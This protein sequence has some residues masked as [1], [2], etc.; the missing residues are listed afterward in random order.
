ML[1]KL[2]VFR[3][4]WNGAAVF[5]KEEGFFQ[6]QRVA[7]P[8][9]G[10]GPALTAWHPVLAENL[11]DARYRAQKSRQEGIWPPLPPENL[12]VDA[13]VPDV[14]EA[15]LQPVQEVTHNF[16]AKTMAEIKEQDPGGTPAEHA[17]GRLIDAWC[18]HYQRQIPWNKAVEILAVVT[19]MPE[20][21]KQK[22][23][24]L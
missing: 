13:R 22:L 18:A 23:L 5:V 12:P 17:A 6:N 4:H 16:T 11:E 24:N 8:V 3:V 10:N 14:A 1:K 7:E 21:E 9:W 19:K 15:V 2:E 20:E